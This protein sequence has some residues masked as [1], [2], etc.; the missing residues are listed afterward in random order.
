M[1]ASDPVCHHPATFVHRF[2]DPFAKTQAIGAMDG[3]LVPSMPFP[4]QHMTK[5]VVYP[6]DMSQ[7]VAPLADLED[8]MWLRSALLDSTQNKPPVKSSTRRV[9]SAEELEYRRLHRRSMQKGY[10]KDYRQRKKVTREGLRRQWLILEE[11]LLRSMKAVRSKK[12]IYQSSGSPA[13]SIGRVEMEVQALRA[14]NHILACILRSEGKFTKAR[15][16]FAQASMRQ[17]V[18]ELSMKPSH[19]HFS[20]SW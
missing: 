7:L 2:C 15:D 20:F 9:R 18:N 19:F 11:D 1:Y 16:F 5:T 4:D 3:H 17:K 13:T 12:M 8:V 10:E 14:E 6:F